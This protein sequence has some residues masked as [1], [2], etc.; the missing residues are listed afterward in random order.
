[1]RQRLGV[2]LLRPQRF[3]DPVL[4]I[5][6]AGLECG[7]ALQMRNAAIGVVTEPVG[8]AQMILCRSILRIQLDGMLEALNR[9]IAAIQ[10]REQKSNLILEMRRFRIERGCLLINC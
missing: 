8:D 10:N 5:E 3:P 6:I 9:L 4:I 2:L 1:M 7:R